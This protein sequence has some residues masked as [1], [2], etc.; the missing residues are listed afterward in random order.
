MKKYTVEYELDEN[1]WWVARVKEIPACLT[2]GRNI[3]QA[4]AR[5]VEA[6]SLFIEKPAEAQLAHVFRLS[7]EAKQKIAE[8]KKA[9]LRAETEAARASEK[10]RDAVELLTSQGL[11]FQD[12]GTL[13]G[14]SRQRAHQLQKT[15]PKRSKKSA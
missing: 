9:R 15:M 2:Q 11:S 10:S 1:E 13:L 7:R 4:Q 8:A 5:I 6:L 3:E 12:V 14:M